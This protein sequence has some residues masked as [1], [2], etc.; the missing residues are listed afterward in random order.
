[1]M[2]AHQSLQLLLQVVI[3]L[4]DSTTTTNLVAAAKSSA[5]PPVFSIR[6]VQL[7]QRLLGDFRAI[8]RTAAE[9]ANGLQ[10]IPYDPSYKPDAHEAMYIEL[11]SNPSL[12]NL[13]ESMLDIGNLDLM[14]DDAT[15]YRH[16]SFYGIAHRAN[17]R[18]WILLRS[19]SAKNVLRRSRRLSIVFQN[20]IYEGINV[21]NV[22]GVVVIGDHNVVKSEFSEARSYSVPRIRG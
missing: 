20:G 11:D 13:V 3:S 16:I 12:K 18:N 1:M 17:D 15:F 14:T 8:S 7:H 10:L 19:I 6:H 4:N 9:T 5:R 21:E 22:E 2:P